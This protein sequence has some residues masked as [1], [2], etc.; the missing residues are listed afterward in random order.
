VVVTL[1]DEHVELYDIAFDWD[2]SDEV[3]WLLGRFAT[4]DP[5]VLEPG[6]GSGRMM[7]AFAR[8][9]I[10]IVGI[11]RSPGMVEF[12]RRR[13]AT[14]GLNAE[15]IVADMT[16]F[17]L[18]RKFGAAICPINT[19][20]HLDAHELGRHLLCVARHLGPGARYLVQVGIV[21]AGDE[22]G[23]SHWKTER[24]GTALR[25]DW[26]G[27][28]RDYARGREEQRSRIEILTG[29]RQGEVVEEIHV[30]TMWTAERWREAIAASP[31]E[32][33]ATF[34]GNVR[35]RPPVP[36]EQ[37]GGLLWHELVVA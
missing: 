12:A 15:V 1:Y 14:A 18:G 31:F 26:E 11:D 21:T 35:E 3:D 23:G 32:Q 10:E 33:V 34:D 4:G 16:D 7:E 27:V 22:P 24:A 25:I 37:G 6:C 28:R 9:G 8:R 30:M 19:L 17:E 20:G 29:P 36:L 2:V 5:S 13:L